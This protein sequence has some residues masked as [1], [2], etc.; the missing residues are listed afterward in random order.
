MAAA[1]A[2][3]NDKVAIGKSCNRRPGLIGAAMTI[4]LKLITQSSTA[5]IVTLTVNPPA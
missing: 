1:V 3:G 2:P 4:N 5:D